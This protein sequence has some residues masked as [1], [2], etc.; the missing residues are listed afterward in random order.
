MILVPKIWQLRYT[1]QQVAWIVT[2]HDDVPSKGKLLWTSITPR[3]SV[4]RV[5]RASPCLVSV[6]LKHLT[7]SDTTASC[8]VKR[9]TRTHSARREL[10]E[11]G[12]RGLQFNA[13]RHMGDDLR[14]HLSDRTYA[15]RL[16]IP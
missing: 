4:I 7:A 2:Y 3:A 11:I 8:R 14:Q 5:I 1:T 12:Y 13:L 16:I 15:Q 10:Q 6:S 9:L